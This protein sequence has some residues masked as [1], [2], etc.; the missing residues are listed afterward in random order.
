MQEKIWNA[1]CKNGHQVLHAGF[2]LLH[3]K[4]FRV[5]INMYLNSI[6][7]LHIDKTRVAEIPPHVRQSL[8]IVHSQLYHGCWW[9]GDARSQ[10]IN[11]HD[12]DLVK[13]E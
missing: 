8:P 2:N 11:N 12:S 5:N 4:F 1:I 13:P 3:A 7:F 6:S 10:G 9:L